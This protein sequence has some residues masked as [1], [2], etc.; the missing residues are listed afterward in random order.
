MPPA[1][2]KTSMATGSCLDSM[3]VETEPRPNHVEYRRSFS[4]MKATLHTFSVKIEPAWRRDAN[5]CNTSI[6]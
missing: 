5:D 4:L 3:K 1:S 2:A 6:L